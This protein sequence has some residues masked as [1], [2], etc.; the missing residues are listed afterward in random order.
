LE[1]RVRHQGQNADQEQMN[2]DIV[3]RA[4]GLITIVFVP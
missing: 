3:S 1:D 2:E 4:N